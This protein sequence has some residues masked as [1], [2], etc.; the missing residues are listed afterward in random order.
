MTGYAY[1]EMLVGVVASSQSID[2]AQAECAVLEFRHGD[3]VVQAEI[4]RADFE[5]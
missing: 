3:F 4:A 5:A 2:L 1:P